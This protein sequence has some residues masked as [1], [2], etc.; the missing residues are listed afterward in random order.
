MELTFLF[1]CQDLVKGPFS[2]RMA[3]ASQ[4]NRR[5]SLDAASLLPNNKDEVVPYLFGLLVPSV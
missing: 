4:W 3:S 2:W 5:P 1:D